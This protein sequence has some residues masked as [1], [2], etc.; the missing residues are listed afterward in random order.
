M[1]G[2]GCGAAEDGVAG[3]RVRLARPRCADDG[4]G[5]QQQF[6]QRSSPGVGGRSLD[7]YLSGLLARG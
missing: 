3:E 5:R 1:L 4:L 6:V 2:A 7:A